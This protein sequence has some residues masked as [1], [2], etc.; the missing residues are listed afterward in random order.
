MVRVGRGRCHGWHQREHP[1]RAGLRRPPSVDDTSARSGSAGWRA[2][3]RYGAFADMTSL[4]RH[5]RFTPESGPQPWPM[6]CRLRA[7]KRH[8]RS[9]KPLPLPIHHRVG[10]ILYWEWCWATPESAKPPILCYWMAFRWHAPTFASNGGKYD[11]F[12]L[13]PMRSDPARS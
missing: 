12:S 8:R 9:T 7:N 5:V 10:A 11:K 1:P 3:D 4:G 2:N 6:P 13:P